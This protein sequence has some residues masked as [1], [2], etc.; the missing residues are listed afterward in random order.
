MSGIHLLTDEKIEKATKS[1]CDGGNLWLKVKKAKNGSLW[2]SWAFFYA[3]PADG[4]R[5]E[6]GL[7]S[8]KAV[9]I[10][11]A[12]AN[13]KQAHA[14]LNEIVPKD[15]IAERR[16]EKRRNATVVGATVDTVIEEY[17]RLDLPSYPEDS[18]NYIR[19]QLKRIS[20]GVGQYAPKDVTPQMLRDDVG[21]GKLHLTNFPTSKK[22]R[23]IMKAIFAKAKAAGL[24][25]SNPALK[26][27]LDVLL[28]RRPKKHVVRSHPSVRREDMYEFITAVH[29]HQ[30]GR[31]KKPGRMT[32]TYACE[33]LAITG[34]RVSEVIEST[35]REIDFGNERWT[36]PW[37]HLKIKNDEIDRPIP[38]TSSMAAILQEMW[39]RTDKHGDYDPVFRGP[40]PKRGYLYTHQAIGQ[41]F[42]SIGWP[43]KVHNHGFRTTL[44]GWAENYGSEHLVEIQL[45][46][47][48]SGTAKAYSAQDDDWKARA[49]MMQR[50]DDYCHTPHLAGAIS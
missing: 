30:D 11:Q 24:C 15:P 50:Y 44:R 3:S 40:K 37:Q 26:G 25:P 35:W 34:I 14:W 32:S 12:R 23:S 6:M 49:E 10:D 20:K 42:E 9:T 39:N 7:G 8:L 17:I 22:L 33:M 1:I 21:Y 31:T 5:R 16:G 19:T 28:P 43:E 48:K 27:D 47:A 4:R 38:I 18:R 13:A 45:H 29:K 46:H 36:V 2:K 41:V